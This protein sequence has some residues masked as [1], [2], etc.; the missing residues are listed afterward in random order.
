MS[1][2]QRTR[3][4]S[5]RVLFCLLLGTLWEMGSGQIRYS[6]PEEMEKGSYVGDV[7]KDLGL[8]PQE[9]SERRVRIISKGRTQRFTLSMKQ[10]HL[11]M[12]EKIDRE[13][14]CA[15][16]P[17]CLLNLQIIAENPMNLYPVEVEILDIND[18][19]PRFPRPEI[20][21]NVSETTAPGARFYLDDARDL[22]VG[23][24]SVQDYWL[25]N[26]SH[27]SLNVQKRPNGGRYAELL[28]DKPMDREDLEIH[29]L[30][31]T[32]IDGGQPVKSG[33]TQIRVLVLDANDNSP[34]FAQS[35]YRTTVE[36]NLPPG[37][38]ILTTEATDADEGSNSDITYSFI[39]TSDSIYKMF[40]VDPKT[41]DI[42][43][44][45][46]IDFEETQFY[47]IAIQAVDGGGL[48]DTAKILLDIVDVN[49]NVPEIKITSFSD[50]IPEDTPPGTIIALFNAED[51]DSGK[52]GYV[53]CS[54]PVHLPFRLEGSFDNYYSLVTY[55]V[56]D[57]EFV[58]E[59]S[60]T[61]TATDRGNPSLSSTKT[62]HLE[63]TDKNDNP[64]VF[65]KKSY[66]A[67]LRE[68]NQPGVSIITVTATDVDWEENA[69]VTY[70]VTE[71]LGQDTSLSSYVSIN[72]ETGVIYALRSFDY[73]QFQEL[74]L[75][76]TAQDGGTPALSSN[77]SVTLLVLDENDN[78]PEILYP[79]LPT[80]GSTGVELAPRS[81]EAGYLVTKVVAVDGDSGQ[82]AWL[83]YHLLKATDP[84]LFSVG[85]HTGEIRT[86]RSFLEKDALKQSLVVVVRD[87]GE[88]PL[89]A[90]VTVTVAVADSIPEILSDLSSLS[91]PADPES[92]LTLYLVVAVA[93]VSCLFLA[94][95]IV[96]L[97]LKLRRWRAERL[98]ESS[99][100]YLG[101]VPA[102]HFVGIDGV[103]AFLQTYSHEVSLTTDS[104]KSQLLFP[105]PIPSDSLP[106]NPTLE[107]NEPLF[108]FQDLVDD[109]GDPKLLQ[110]AGK[111]RDPSKR[112]HWD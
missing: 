58:Q 16:S 60:I 31:L 36:E 9:L 19:A 62:T 17:K 26:D 50:T 35:F 83:S 103:R 59:Y 110:L 13:E 7:A 38:I 18:N 89:S 76:V 94:F 41:G 34:I 14:V 32:A 47:E 23:I 112:K 102:S 12:N 61:I 71:G 57:R 73:E 87:N 27:F 67:N 98:L 70:S 93:A 85:L 15:D 78:T 24:N 6:V 43:V 52:N 44:T 5:G 53:V 54:I 84:G 100:G 28:L 11:F 81:A 21:I 101:G 65:L 51:R 92:S 74:K 99:S 1:F 20:R 3:D 69:Q 10:G 42:K 90:T 109:K 88:P 33:T 108:P 48:A 22:D 104:R 30:T 37:S 46:R 8:E 72:S 2:L 45:G 29:V 55:E 82:N 96:L 79:S 75:L 97:A 95:I 91:T 105:Q 80:D 107:K 49:D 39:Q 86:A 63:I 4:C 68:N 25:S 66:S 56:L 77:V 64:P 106:H 40:Q 111:S